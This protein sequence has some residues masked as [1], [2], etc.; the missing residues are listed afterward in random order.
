MNDLKLSFPS[1]RDCVAV[2][3]NFVGEIKDTIGRVRCVCVRD[4][5]AARPEFACRPRDP[6]ER[7]EVQLLHPA[8]GGAQANK[9]HDS[10]DVGE[11]INNN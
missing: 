8:G 7:R 5:F 1:L 6:G 3:T 10:M 4:L 2:A 11:P 9:F